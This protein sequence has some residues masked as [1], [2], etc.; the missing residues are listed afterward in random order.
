LADCFVGINSMDSA[1]SDDVQHLDG[2]IL[3]KSTAV[4]AY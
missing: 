3:E 2:Y 4:C 1:A